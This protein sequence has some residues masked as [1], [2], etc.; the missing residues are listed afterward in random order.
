MNYQLEDQLKIWRGYSKIG[1]W[2][3]MFVRLENKV[4]YFSDKNKQNCKF[5][6]YI[7]LLKVKKVGKFQFTI[8]NGINV[9]FFKTTSQAK[10]AE[11]VETL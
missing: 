3:C 11:W 5:Q 9:I 10:Q 8:H 7:K 6:I 2:K 1:F 4:L